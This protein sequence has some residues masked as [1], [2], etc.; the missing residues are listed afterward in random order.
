MKKY[1]ILLLLSFVVVGVNGQTKKRTTKRK[2]TV[3]QRARTPEQMVIGKHMLS[4]QWISW[5]YYG[6]CNITKQPDGTLRCKGEQ[7]SRENDDY[8]RIDGEISIVDAKHLVFTGTIA[9]K[10]YHINNGQECLR[11]GTFDFESTQ[12]RKYWRL[13][14]MENPC[15]MCAD[16]VDIYFK[17]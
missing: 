8:L 17:R 14:Q 12:N 7:L 2:A 16:Y 13:Q 1:L 6:T 3:T 10:I 11:E 4:L 9:T 15:D 5:D